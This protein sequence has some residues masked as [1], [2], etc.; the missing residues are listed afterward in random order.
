MNAI[1]A[2]VVY[3][4][5]HTISRISKE[6]RTIDAVML[7]RNTLGPFTK[8]CD[9]HQDADHLNWFIGLRPTKA[10]IDNWR[11]LS[12]QIQSKILADKILLK[13]WALS[14][15]M[16]EDIKRRRKALDLEAEALLRR[17][18]IRRE[19]FC[20][21]CGAEIM[22]IAHHH[23]NHPGVNLCEDCRDQAIIGK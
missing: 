22:G 21:L 7:L 2:I 5:M 14:Q 20:G 16:S 18:D 1:F 19:V 6:T 23:Y 12:E 3:A 17:S 11:N 9:S 4:I 15:V 10:V 13:Q 8:L